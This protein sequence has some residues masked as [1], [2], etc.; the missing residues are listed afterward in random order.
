MP[1]SFNQYNS[2]SESSSTLVDEMSGLHLQYDLSEK[3][4]YMFDIEKLYPS[5]PL[6]QVPFVIKNLMAKYFQGKSRWGA[7]VEFLFLLLQLV[8]KAQIL[9]FT[10]MSHSHGCT[11]TS[12][13][14]QV[15]GIATGLLCSSQ[16]ANLLLLGLDHMAKVSFDKDIFFFKRYLGDILVVVRNCWTGERIAEV[17]NIWHSN[18]KITSDDAEDGSNVNFLDLSIFLRPLLEGRF[19]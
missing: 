10:S 12:L 3:A 2:I 17:L 9:A 4:L 6:E 8:L 5:L 15:V 1:E 18:I 13:Y 11:S 19:P 16:I 14:L 7:K